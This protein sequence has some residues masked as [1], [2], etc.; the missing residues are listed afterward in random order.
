[1]HTSTLR[2]Q[3]MFVPLAYP[4]GEAQ[5]DFGKAMVVMAGVERT[6]FPRLPRRRSLNCD[7]I[8]VA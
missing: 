2:G 5:V 7:K 6:L 1:M 3:E 4:A 8:Q